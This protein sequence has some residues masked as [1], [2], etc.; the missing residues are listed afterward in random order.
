MTFPS[1]LDDWRIDLTKPLDLLVRD[2]L[3]ARAPM[4]I[5][6]DTVNLAGF[7]AV[8]VYRLLNEPEVRERWANCVAQQM[9]DDDLI[10][11][12]G[13]VGFYRLEPEAEGVATLLQLKHKRKLWDEPDPVD[14]R[15]TLR[16]TLQLALDAIRRKKEP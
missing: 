6:P 8:R 5:H 4:N 11:R 14:P 7:Q 3:A 1:E 2:L 15:V 10:V 13:A 9:L 16:W 12:R